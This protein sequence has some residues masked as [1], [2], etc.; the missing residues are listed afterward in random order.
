M[1]RPTKYDVMLQGRKIAGAAQRK[2]KA[3]FLHQG[4]IALLCPDPELLGAVELCCLRCQ[5]E[6]R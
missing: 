6:R 5:S 3:G 2:T 4:T 1:A